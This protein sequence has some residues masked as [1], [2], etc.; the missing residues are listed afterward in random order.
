MQRARRS[1]CLLRRSRHVRSRLGRARLWADV[2]IFL[3]SDFYE[4]QGTKNDLGNLA[5]ILEERLG[6]LGK[7]VADEEDRRAQ[8]ALEGA[9]K[10]ARPLIGSLIEA[11]RRMRDVESGVKARVQDRREAVGYSGE[12]VA[13][14]SK[15]HSDDLEEFSIEANDTILFRTASLRCGASGV[16]LSISGANAEW[17]RATNDELTRAIRQNVRV[18]AW[19]RKAR[20]AILFLTLLVSSFAA[21]AYGIEWLMSSI[22]AGLVLAG[23]SAAPYIGAWQRFIEGFRAGFLPLMPLVVGG[24][25]A[26]ILSGESWKAARRL[27]AGFFP[28]FI[29]TDQP[30][31]P[32]MAKAASATWA[33]S[34]PS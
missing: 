2:K 5:T 6:D 1:R 30:S 21:I 28:P 12:P 26:V 8:E 29:V 13:V 16:R 18:P 32:R 24:L 9:P 19:V 33:L 22:F 23:E 20:V 17:V 4:W 14:L 3:D 25:F 27:E 31:K 15:V 11:R 10:S 7:S 34:S